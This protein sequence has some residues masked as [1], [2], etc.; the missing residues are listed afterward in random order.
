MTI[1]YGTIEEQIDLTERLVL[2]GKAARNIL[3]HD[4][5]VLVLH[6]R[7]KGNVIVEAVGEAYV[8]GTV[9]GNVANQ[10]GHVEIYGT[11]QGTVQAVDQDTT[12]DDDATVEGEV[13]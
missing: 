10:D 4:G 12:I 2:H 5:G 11:V 6:G 9:E 8:Y 13:I 7:C 3:V 1:E